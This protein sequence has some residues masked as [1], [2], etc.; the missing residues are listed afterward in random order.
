MR[1]LIFVCTGD[2]LGQF[3]T[4]L[5]SENSVLSTVPFQNF[6]GNNFGR[7]NKGLTVNS[8]F[9]NIFFSHITAASGWNI[10][11]ILNM[12][13]RTVKVSLTSSH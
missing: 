3:I 9:N 1:R 4:V 5:S 12:M 8:I 7:E 13:L 10:P 2:G 6:K 11:Q